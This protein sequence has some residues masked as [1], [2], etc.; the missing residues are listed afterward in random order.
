MTP[1]TYVL[2]VVL[3]IG[4]LMVWYGNKRKAPTEVIVD[5]DSADYDM[6]QACQ[7]IHKN[8][9]TKSLKERLTDDH[10]KQM[11]AA[12]EQYLDTQPEITLDQENLLF[13]QNILKEQE[14]EYTTWEIL[15]VFSAEVV[16]LKKI[17]LL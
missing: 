6:D 12:Q 9:K 14:L 13:V 1:K 10:I 7:L 3:A 2:L 5:A 16:Y 4:L 17:G 8:V 11:I 15:E